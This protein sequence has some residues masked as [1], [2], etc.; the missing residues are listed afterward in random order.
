M[1]HLT[2]PCHDTTTHYGPLGPGITGVRLWLFLP[3]SPLSLAHMPREVRAVPA[4][5]GTTLGHQVLLPLPMLQPH[6]HL[7]CQDPQYRLW[8]L[9]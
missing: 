1:S 8:M 7:L 5:Q 2:L 9:D 4:A 6:L 3:T